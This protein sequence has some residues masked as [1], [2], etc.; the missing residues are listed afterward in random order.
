MVDPVSC[1]VLGEGKVFDG[2]SVNFVIESKEDTE[3]SLCKGDVCR[4]RENVIV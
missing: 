3:A 1:G 4:L 2:P